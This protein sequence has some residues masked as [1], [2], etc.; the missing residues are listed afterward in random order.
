MTEPTTATSLALVAAGFSVATLLPGMDGNAVIG[1][2]AGAA[3]VALHARDVSSVSRGIY[4][5]ISWVMGYLAAPAVA[6][7]SGLQETGVAAFLAAA[8]VIAVT[9][10][11]LD[12]VKTIDITSWLRRGGGTP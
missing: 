11:L 1:A 7:L 9:L 3:L 4:L 12:R 10:Q 5:V 8:M 6:R 2:F